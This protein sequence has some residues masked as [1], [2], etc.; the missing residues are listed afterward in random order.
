MSFP[1]I[2]DGQAV[3]KSLKEGRLV[4]PKYP[5]NSSPFSLCCFVIY[6]YIFVLAWIKQQDLA[7]VIYIKSIYSYLHSES[8]ARSKL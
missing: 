7:V 2:L 1:D 8:D 4:R 6:V 3:I 5:E